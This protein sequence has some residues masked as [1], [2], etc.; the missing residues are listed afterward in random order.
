M[1]GEMRT[2][3]TQELSSS[4]SQG[5]AEWFGGGATAPQELLSLLP[6][7][8]RDVERP[9]QETAEGTALSAAGRLLRPPADPPVGARSLP[10][11]PSRHSQDAV[12]PS[13]LGGCWSV[14]G[15]K[16]RTGGL[17]SADGLK[18]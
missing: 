16:A 11:L 5:H 17:V 8:T 9:E 4:S 7:Q 12:D 10:E 1:E 13:R 15:A 2:Y 18:F 3:F 6:L 14:G